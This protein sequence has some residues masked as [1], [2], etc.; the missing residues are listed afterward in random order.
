[1]LKVKV[2]RN[3]SNDIG[4]EI[5][6]RAEAYYVAQIKAK[7]KGVSCPFHGTMPCIY[8]L[9]EIGGYFISLENECCLSF[10]ELCAGKLH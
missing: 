9:P 6:T 10:S 5:D 4:V 1:M 8:I 3:V 7:L 2:K